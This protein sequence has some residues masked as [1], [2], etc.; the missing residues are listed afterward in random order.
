[1]GPHLSRYSC[2]LVY[3]LIPG[4]HFHIIRAFSA[5]IFELTLIILV[6]HFE[7]ENVSAKWYH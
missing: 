2:L 6:E 3:I 1:M 5:L 7:V 4:E